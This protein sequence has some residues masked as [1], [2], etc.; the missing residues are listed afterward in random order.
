M[1][2]ARIAD[3]FAETAAL[4]DLVGEDPRRARTYAGI[5]RRLASLEEPIEA[6][7]ARNALLDVPGIGEGT[8][9]RV[10]SLLATGRMDV[11][12]DLR[13]RVPAGLVDLLRVPGLGPR[14]VA[15]LHRALGVETLA[16]LEY[17]CV[18]NRL[19]DLPGFGPKVQEAVSQGVASLRASQGLRLLSQ[20]RRA[21]ARA[22]GRLEREPSALRLAVAGPVRRMAKVVSEVPL[23]ATAHDPEAL[24][25]AFAHLPDSTCLSREGRGARIALDEGTAV[26]LRVVEADAFATE[27]FH[28]TGADAHVA[29][30]VAHARRAGFD[31]TPQALSRDGA[32]V[33]LEDERDLYE[34]LGLPW[35]PPECREDGDLANPP[36]ED[37]VSIGDVVGVLHAHTLDS[38]G[39]ASLRDMAVR[40][41]REGFSWFAVT[42][43]SRSA[44]YARGLSEER[45]RAQWVEVERLNATGEAGIPVLKGTEC[46]ILPDGS[47]DFPDE[48]LRGFD[49][50]VGSVHAG[51]RRPKEEATERLVRAARSPWIHVLGHPTGRYLLGRAGAEIDLDRV[52]AACAETG[53]A[54]ELNCQ[55]RRMDLDEEGVA[56]AAAKGVLVSI[57][58]DAHGPNDVENVVLGVGVARRARLRRRDVLTALPLEEFRAWCARRR[59]LP[60]PPPLVL[61]GAA[62]SG[63]EE[64]E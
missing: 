63:D 40:A 23:L 51:L 35:F 49:V 44:G 60:A 17:A 36:P 21:A 22:L 19:R 32:R 38:D 43:H 42:D 39:N 10:R 11:L 28:A 31:L 52:L 5:A 55:P 6:L 18:E 56:R 45:V 46:D 26:S 20:A 64:D 3:A 61:G 50:V 48:C 2:N 33:P 62:A 24:L 59:G 57:D 1:D 8:D 34:R 29:A 4:L 58:P 30:V 27:I 15:D 13:A 16:D 47:L 41:R 14:R 7:V 12:D 53:T 9:R 25:S 37:L 54:I